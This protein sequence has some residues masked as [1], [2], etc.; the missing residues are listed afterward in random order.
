LQIPKYVKLP[1][2]ID[3]VENK[4]FIFTKRQWLGGLIGAAAGIIPFFI[5]WFVAG[6]MIGA[7]T[8]F[9]VAAPVAFIFIYENNGVTF[10]DRIQFWRNF[11][12]KP[13]VRIYKSHTALEYFELELEKTQLERSLKNG[14]Y[15][16]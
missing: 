1:I 4:A 8:L 9:C 6:V 13:A 5:A 10:K 3:S 2:D 12:K 7:I 11:L 16:K 14:Y 15:Y